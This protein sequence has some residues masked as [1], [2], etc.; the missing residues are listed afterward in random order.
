MDAIRSLLA[1]K[2]L[3]WALAYREISD[4]YIGSYLGLLWSVLQPLGLVIVLAVAVSG[5]SLR[6]FTNDSNM[7]IIIIC[8]LSW[9]IVSQVVISTVGCMRTNRSFLSQMDFPVEVIPLKTVVATTVVQGGLLCLIAVWGA[10]TGQVPFISLPLLALC[11]IAQIPLCLGLGWLFASFGAYFKDLE[12]ALPTL[13]LINMYLLPIFYSTE[14]APAPI[15][16][17]VTY[18]PLTPMVNTYRM[19]SSPT[20]QIDTLDIVAFGLLSTAVCF[21]GW[22]CFAFLK[23]GFSELG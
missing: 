17:L 9:Y 22:R 19:A 5:F 1:N 10:A 11:L 16:S 2:H 3:I 8:F 15:K 6:S 4:R 18:N 12:Q 13:L 23:P 14:S 21:I 20:L 7:V